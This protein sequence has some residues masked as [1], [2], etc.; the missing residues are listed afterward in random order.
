VIRSAAALALIALAALVAGCGSD[1]GGAAKVE[2]GHL[3]PQIDPDGPNGPGSARSNEAKARGS[4]AGA[5]AARGGADAPC[6]LVSRGQAGAIA[7]E[8]MLKPVQAPQ[9]PTCI[10]R[11]QSGKSPITLAVQAG[12]LSD[13]SRAMHARTPVKVAGRT[14][15]CGI[16]DQS[17]LYL[18]VPNAGVLTVTGP[19]AVAKR[20]AARALSHL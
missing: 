10:Y 8:A 13:L 4:I 19:C 16:R 15:V 1:G 3:S 18:D 7:G 5:A 14:G 20:F 2:V 9:G 12:D 6:T 17:V 11:Y